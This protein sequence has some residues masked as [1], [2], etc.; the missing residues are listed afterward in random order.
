LNN[1][2]DQLDTLFLLAELLLLFCRLRI[3]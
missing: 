2:G 1:L 3:L